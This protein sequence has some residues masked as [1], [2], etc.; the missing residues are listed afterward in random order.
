MNIRVLS[1]ADEAIESMAFHRVVALL[2]TDRDHEQNLVLTR[3][4]A[5][6]SVAVSRLWFF[7]TF[8]K[9][10]LYLSSILLAQHCALKLPSTQQTFAH[11]ESLAPSQ[12]NKT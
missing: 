6:L 2:R 8:S 4:F 12:E 5:L 9:Y 10:P 11:S 3:L 7:W 1:K